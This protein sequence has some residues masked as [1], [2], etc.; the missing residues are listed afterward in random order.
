EGNFG[1]T[2]TCAP[3]SVTVRDVKQFHESYAAVTKVSTKLRG[4]L[5]SPSVTIA[6]VCAILARPAP[7]RVPR[8][9]MPI[10]MRTIRLYF[11]IAGLLL[12]AAPAF[13]QYQPRPLNDSAAGEDYHIEGAIG[14]WF[15]TSD[16]TVASSGGGILSGIGGSEINAQRDLGMPTSARLP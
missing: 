5:V 7:A 13:A 2:P 6:R 3:P 12:T 4:L 14:F 1:A 9:L 16:L 15:P 8:L 11:W 10:T